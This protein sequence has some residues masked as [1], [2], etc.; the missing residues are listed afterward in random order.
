MF[1]DKKSFIYMQE[2][3]RNKNTPDCHQAQIYC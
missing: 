2:I 3:K 1:R